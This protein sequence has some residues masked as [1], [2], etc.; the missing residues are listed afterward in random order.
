M[1]K[2]TCF[3]SYSH[4]DKNI[5]KFEKINNL[6]TD[7]SYYVNYSEKINKSRYS[8]ETI[9]KYL[10]DRIAGSS[11][12]I[13]LLTEDLLTYN[14]EKIQ[15]KYGDFLNSGWIYNEISA[16]LRDWEDNRINGL[17]CVVEDNLMYQIQIV[18]KTIY[19]YYKLPKIL[20]ENQD[21]IIFVSYSNFI[22]NHIEFVNKAI[23]NREEQI[24]S[25]GKRFKIVYDLHKK[26]SSW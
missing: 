19:G 25:N 4:N 5:I 12:T 23:K 22:K 2:T 10:H 26:F 21:Y 8:D 17:I 7:S 13:L 16:S 6:V 15:Y 24:R 18:N 1:S 11:C 14:N 20:Y 3:I 9:W